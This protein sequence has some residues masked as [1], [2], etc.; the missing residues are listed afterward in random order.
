MRFLAAPRLRTLLR[1]GVPLLLIALLSGCL[2]PPEPRTDA[3]RDVFNL[4]IAILALAAIVFIGVEGFIVYAIIR[5]RRKPGDETLPPQHHGN[6]VI[7]LIWTGIPTVIVLIL[8]ILSV[9][10]LGT[11]QARS[12]NPVV[13]EVEGFQWQWRFHYEDGVTVE[14]GTPDKPPQLWVPVGE[15]VR[16]TLTSG[17]VIHSFYVP[18]F[19]IKEDLIPVGEE[20]TSNDLEFTVSEPG[21]YSGQCAEFCGSAHADMT[22]EVHAVSRAEFDAWL[23][24]GGQPPPPPPSEPAE[25]ECETTVELTALDGQTAFDADRLEVPAGEPFCILFT[26]EDGVT[27]DVGI[28]DAAGE[29]KFNGEDIPGGESVTY[30]VGGLEPGTYEF[31]CTIHPQMNGELV[32]GE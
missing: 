32:V 25:G 29:E 14:P 12:E 27:H 15:P 2:L 8:F 21:T 16:L 28:L 7:E 26:N 18:Q 13:I 20:G 4:Y 23:A 19:L 1:T 22:F 30:L 6:S 11:V 10:T 3:G 24:D 17:D 31:L 5:Y 9:I